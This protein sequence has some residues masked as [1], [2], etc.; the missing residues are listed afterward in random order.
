EYLKMLENLSIFEYLNGGSENEFEE[1]TP[2]Y[3]VN[4]IVR[5]LRTF[6]EAVAR[7]RAQQANSQFNQG[8]WFR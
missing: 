3:A 8:T 1:A 2:W 6:K 7:L 5:E 4:P